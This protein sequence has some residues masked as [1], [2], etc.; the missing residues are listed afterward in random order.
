MKDT[1]D[2][3]QGGCYLMKT[4]NDGCPCKNCIVRAMCDG[5]KECKMWRNWAWNIDLKFLRLKYG[6]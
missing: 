6:N 4:T 3:C 1:C 5:S 2:G